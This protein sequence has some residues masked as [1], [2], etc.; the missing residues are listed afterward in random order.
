MR[1]DVDCSVSQAHKDEL[2]LEGHG[3]ELVSNSVALIQ[4]ATQLAA[5]LLENCG[6]YLC[7]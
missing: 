7:F 5:R 1:S 2:I 3:V 6:W 4:Q